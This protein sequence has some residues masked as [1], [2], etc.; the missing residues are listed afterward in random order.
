MQ[1]NVVYICCHTIASRTC[2]IS[3]LSYSQ[4]FDTSGKVVD[5]EGQP[6]PGLWLCG[7]FTAKSLSVLIRDELQ[8]P[9]SHAGAASV[10][11][12]Q[13]KSLVQPKGPL[14]EFEKL[15][16]MPSAVWLLLQRRRMI[17]GF[18]Q[19]LAWANKG[20]AHSSARPGHVDTENG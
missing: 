2:K 16:Q 1:R 20:E 9:D 19:V 7:H 3:H 6:A 13:T 11:L 15:K 17:C 14:E 5:S 12:W 4:A 10:L 18:G 8:K